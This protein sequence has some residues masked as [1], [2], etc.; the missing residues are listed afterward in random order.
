MKI[1]T[2][3]VN[4]SGAIYWRAEYACGSRGYGKTEEEAIRNLTTEFPDDGAKT[5]VFD[6]PHNWQ[7]ES[8]KQKE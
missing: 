4:I 8:R 2:Q 5:E 3:K 1:I 6:G 7:Q